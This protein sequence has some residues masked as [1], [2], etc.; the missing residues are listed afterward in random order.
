M[1]GALSTNI[2]G[3]GI[4]RNL[5]QL[6]WI[7]VCHFISILSS[8]RDLFSLYKY[9]Q[10]RGS[11]N[12]N[13]LL[14]L[15]LLFHMCTSFYYYL[16]IPSHGTV[17]FLKHKTYECDVCAQQRGAPRADFHSRQVQFQAAPRNSWDN[18]TFSSSRS[19]YKALESTAA[20]RK[21]ID[22]CLAKGQ[23]QSKPQ[24]HRKP[25][26]IN[27]EVLQQKHLILFCF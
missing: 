11:K 24:W 13:I 12:V 17:T 26:P 15:L 14:L 7:K 9:Q 27:K 8:S 21:S 23:N 6:R 19:S 5:H 2:M 18:D 4:L 10:L 20:W 3:P 25:L 16:V 22:N 1:Q